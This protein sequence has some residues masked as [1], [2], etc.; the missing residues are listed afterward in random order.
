MESKGLLAFKY[1]ESLADITL[2]KE[3][4]KVD[5]P[6]KAHKVVLAAASGLF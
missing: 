5:P 2:T 6:M 1:F 4:S 3:E